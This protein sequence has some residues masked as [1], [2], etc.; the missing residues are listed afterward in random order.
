MTSPAGT[1]DYENPPVL[2]NG[3]PSALADVLGGHYVYWWFDVG[4]GPV[5]LTAVVS[6]PIEG[7]PNPQS[8]IQVWTVP[9]PDTFND[10]TPDDYDATIGSL[11][12]PAVFTFTATAG[13]YLIGA[14]INAI[15]SQSGGGEIMLTGTGTPPS[16][17]PEPGGFHLVG[18]VRVSPPPLPAVAVTSP[19]NLIESVAV[20]AQALRLRAPSVAPAIT[21]VPPG[22]QLVVPQLGPH[23]PDGPEGPEGP[24]GPIG[25][26]GDLDESLPDLTLIFE[27]GLV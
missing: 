23:G 6:D 17:D 9:E 25:P 18:N 12:T 5:T 3:D 19:A 27:N 14:G 2:I 11:D 15:A 22:N 24:T 8:Q 7:Y 21:N 26:V 20:P 1:E 13:R 10:V 16:P 4:A